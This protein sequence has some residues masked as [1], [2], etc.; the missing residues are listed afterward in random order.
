MRK[1][2]IITL[3]MLVSVSAA[4]PI[5]ASSSGAMAA[6]S[7]GRTPP[8]G[9]HLATLRT[10]TNLGNGFGDSVAV[11]G[12]VAVVG[13]TFFEGP[14]DA[15]AYVFTKTASGWRQT[16]EL[17]GSG[18]DQFGYSVAISG[19]TAI[20]GAPSQASEGAAYVFSDATGTWKQAAKLKGSDTATNDEFGYSVAISGTTAIVG[21]L[22]HAAPPVGGTC[23][24]TRPAPGSRLPS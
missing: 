15:P 8:I 4:V 14:A 2:R 20:V 16:A 6:A 7:P 19:T 10:A 18:F 22:G 13:Y 5:L 1:S 3:S 17:K 11:S 23:S 21:A 24:P 12:T 9:T